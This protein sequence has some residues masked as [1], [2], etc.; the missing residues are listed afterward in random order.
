MIISNQCQ[1][2]SITHA[3][4]KRYQLVINATDVAYPHAELQDL[5]QS[6]QIHL[7]DQALWVRKFK[8]LRSCRTKV[9][10]LV[11]DEWT[12][13]HAS[14]R[15]YTNSG[16]IDTSELNELRDEHHRDRYTLRMACN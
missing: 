12:H 6:S 4:L 10:C 15:T 8:Q 11:L 14:H 1:W 9:L 16:S 2:L 5:I 13:V 7:A 3:Y